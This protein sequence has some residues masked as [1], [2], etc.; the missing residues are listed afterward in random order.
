M[1]TAGFLKP[2]FLIASMQK[3]GTTGELPEGAVNPARIPRLLWLNR[4]LGRTNSTLRRNITPRRILEYNHVVGYYPR[5]A[6]TDARYARDM[7][8]EADPDLLRYHPGLMENS[9]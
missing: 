9:A 7:L 2:T 5:L 6:E 3:A 1:N 8:L 4:L